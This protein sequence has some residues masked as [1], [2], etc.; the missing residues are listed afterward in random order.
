MEHFIREIKINR[1]RHLSNMVITLNPESRQNLMITGKNGSGK[2]SLLLAMNRKFQLLY[3]INKKVDLEREEGEIR[4]LF[5]QY[6]DLDA[7]YRNGDFIIAFFPANRK[8]QVIRAHGVEDIKLNKVYDIDGEPGK[9]LHKYMVHLKTQQAYARN[10]GD[11]KNV[12]LIQ[13]WFDRFVNAL[14]IL[15]D[16]DSITLEYDYKEYNFKIHEDGRVPFGFD[17]LS[18]GFSSVIHIVSDLILRMDKD[19]LYHGRL[20][21]YDTE[22]IVM[23]DELETHLHLELQKKIL[24]FLTS[25]FPRIQ[26]IITTHSPYILNSIANAKAYDLEKCVEL[27]NLFAYS[28]EGIAEGYFGMDEYSDELKEKIERYQYLVEKA[29][30]TGEERA[31][32][33]K[34]RIQ[35]KDIPRNLAPEA[36]NKFEEIEGSRL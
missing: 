3:E 27:E 26:F 31:E 1:L 13:E 36:R 11:M 12:E 14:R 2:T 6:G 8:A 5:N 20:S 30:V 7:L 25:F 29:E 21:V 23:I 22:G 34:L 33:A 32:R 16:D 19:W 24:P 17:E 15:L 10:E 35:L 4:I 28:S 18:D 9:L